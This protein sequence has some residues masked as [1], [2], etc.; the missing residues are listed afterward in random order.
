MLEAQETT[1]QY[2]QA[3]SPLMF[4]YPVAVDALDELD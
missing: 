2:K 3:C 1:A 4:T